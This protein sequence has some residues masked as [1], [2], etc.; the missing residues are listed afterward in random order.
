M[1]INRRDLLAV[2]TGALLPAVN[3]SS[4]AKTATQTYDVAA[5]YWPAYH[6][7]PRWRQ[8][9]P[10]GEGEWETI[11]HA[12]PKF[13]GHNQPRVPLWGFENEA[14]P[15]VM[16]KK[17]AAASAHGV[18]VMIFD[19]YWYDGQPFLENTLNEGFLAASNPGRVRFFLMWANHDAVTIW[20][21]KRS[22]KSEL[23]WPGS[24]DRKNLDTIAERVIH[25]YFKHPGYYTIKGRPVFSI[26]D[27]SNLIKGL[28]G[29][30][31]T[32]EALDS[33]RAQVK[34]AGFPGLHLQAILWGRVPQGGDA[35]I[36]GK[37]AT[38]S[39]VVKYLG[40]D[41]LT[42]YQWVHA[43]PADG[44]YVAWGEAATGHWDRWRTEF[45]VPYYPH[46]S[47]G[48]DSNPRFTSFHEHLITNP[49]PDSF[50][51]YLYKAKQYVNRY[52]TPKLITI[53]SWNEWSEGSYLEPD[54]RWGFG[55]LEAVR[56]VMSGAWDR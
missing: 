16:S 50:A 26:Y 29:L 38:Q 37:L 2:A 56:K 3:R 4:A 53:N 43:V 39:D 7:E 46:V 45:P 15:S 9:F 34:A 20:D 11:R 13:P 30:A 28:G 1:P 41:S 17:L 18:N 5:Y 47:I 33:F 55:Y 22:D 51:A 42:S 49:T 12:K 48:W 21:I 44:D 32:K 19:W 24:V 52:C 54:M 10:G 25:R 8:F 35:G 6:D 27:L 40:I 23:I 14:D 31:A 36:A